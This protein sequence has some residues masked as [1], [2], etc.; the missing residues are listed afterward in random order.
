M[1][2][3][4]DLALNQLAGDLRAAP[5]KLRTHWSEEARAARC[6]TIE[7]LRRLAKRTV[8]RPIFDYADGAAWDEVTARR[9]RSAFEDVTLQPKVLIDSGDVDL[10][11]TVLGREIA[12]P[13]IGAPTG[14]TGLQHPDGE[15]AIARAC[16][17]ADTVYTLSTMASYTLEESLKPPRAALVSALRDERQGPCGGAALPRGGRR[18]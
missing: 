6:G 4:A 2:Q 18:L 14:L 3:L 11:T 12:L 1:N 7:E 15:V 9:N 17:A 5:Q 10:R 13:I 8:P 16:H